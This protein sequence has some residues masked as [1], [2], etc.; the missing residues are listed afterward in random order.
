MKDKQFFW[1]IDLD[2]WAVLFWQ[3]QIYECV[4]L[5]WIYSS[6]TML[7]EKSILRYGVETVY[8]LFINFY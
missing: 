8:A 3:R 4:D 5:R 2:K 1:Q 6:K 7:D